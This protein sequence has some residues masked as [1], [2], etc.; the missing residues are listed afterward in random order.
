[1]PILYLI[2]LRK[3]YT[4]G[5]IFYGQASMYRPRHTYYVTVLV[6]VCL[7]TCMILAHTCKTVQF[8]VI[9]TVWIGV[10]TAFA[11]LRTIL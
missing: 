1:M 6:F 9:A 3:G 7:Y 5:R 10:I 2:Y 11:H 4:S 8:C